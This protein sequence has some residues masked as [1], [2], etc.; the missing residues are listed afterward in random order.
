[1]VKDKERIRVCLVGPMPPPYGGMS[2]Q[3]AQLEN[4]LQK[5]RLE[6]RTLPVNFSFP[7]GLRFID[8]LKYIRAVVRLLF[9]MVILCRRLKG[10]DL[11]HILSNS[12]LSFFLYTAP[13][14]FVGKL[15]CCK[16]IINY[17]GGLAR[18]FL[19]KYKWIVCQILRMADAL[20]VPSEYL[21]EIFK[22]YNFMPEIVPN[23]INLE[24]FFKV[25]RH[26]G[27]VNGPIRL[28]VV[29]N[30]EKIYNVACA[31]RA[32]RD[33]QREYPQ[34]S[35]FIVGEGSEEITLK[36]LVLD[37]D[38]DDVNFVG[39]V[40]NQ[41]IPELYR[42]A[43]VVL[44]TSNVDNFPISVL[45]AFVSGV[46]VVST[47]VGGIPYLI[48][49]G[50]SGLLVN[51]DDDKGMAQCVLRLLKDKDLYRRISENGQKEAL[52]YSWEYVRPQLFT[53]Y[54]SVLCEEGVSL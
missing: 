10:V 5:E 21:V 31:V 19:K 15:Y 7:R 13:A 22:Q 51:R 28:L 35:L 24:R 29:R 33:I 52:K 14:I 20:I 2:V 40:S 30:L 48:K 11:I 46:P 25:Q 42:K 43:T 44:N 37:M 23:I 16:V 18:E 1:M 47:N 27:S 17:R 32:F 34:A 39:R 6:V 50:V 8:N 26:G 36:R 3:T 49:D 54:K 45:E 41:D 4:L 12:Y 38:L 53:V 9:Y